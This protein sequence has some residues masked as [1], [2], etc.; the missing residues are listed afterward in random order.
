[1]QFNLTLH[2]LWR[3]RRPSMSTLHVTL[4]CLK[5]PAT[6][7]SIGL[8]LANDHW[9]K[10][11]FPSWWTGKLSDFAG[12]FFF[13]F[14]IAP[15]LGLLLDRKSFSPRM[16]GRLAFALTGIW[17]TLLKTL[18]LANAATRALL[19]AVLGHAVQIVLDHTDLIA[20]PVLVP[21]WLLWMYETQARKDK[22]GKRGWLAL[23]LGVLATAA[24]SPAPPLYSVQRLEAEGGKLYAFGS[25][26]SLD[27]SGSYNRTTGDLPLAISTDGGRTWTPGFSP[28][29][30]FPASS[31]QPTQQGCDP[32]NAQVC[33]RI[34][35]EQVE[36]S[37]DGGKTYQVV[38][39]IPWGRRFFMER[40]I[41][42]V[43]LPPPKQIDVGPYDFIFTAPVGANGLSTVFFAMGNEGVMVRRPEGVWER[44]AVWTA[45]PTRFVASSVFEAFGTLP[46]ETDVVAFL[47]LLTFSFLSFRTA[48][49]FKRLG[50][51]T[52]SVRWAIWPLVA[53]DA[54]A[55][56]GWA[57]WALN[58]YYRIGAFSILAV[59]LIIVLGGQSLLVLIVPL[60]FIILP[61]ILIIWTWRRIARL[62]PSSGAAIAAFWRTVR[63][64]IALALL[65]FGPLVLWTFGTIPLYELAVAVAVLFA[66]VLVRWGNKGVPG[67]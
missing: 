23:A 3:F 42:A 67:E 64:S 41:R 66:V 62:W 31:R 55:L 19:G 16:I 6:L 56:L 22:P 15:L 18:P 34:L 20:L 47:G 39:S 33:Y 35:P 61:G 58:G 12:L 54:L 28:P 8:L 45:Q 60:V 36:A 21:A 65:T 37:R 11:S 5:Y 49:T 40:A 24:T 63:F 26:S 46:V 14:L 2:P 51:S 17:F 9:L 32:G 43:I 29:T 48:S 27:S 44:Y 7:L 53:L 59:P 4:R 38:W 57:A 50:S 10:A 1:L 52:R 30:P 13:P 25:A